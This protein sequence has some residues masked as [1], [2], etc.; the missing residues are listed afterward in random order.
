[1]PTIESLLHRRTDLS[2]FL[3][4]FTRDTPT[5]SAAARDNLLSIL[6]SQRLEARN[7][8]GMEIGR[9]HV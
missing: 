8:Y 3:V 7:T 9:A 5:P 1:M 2:T 4:H 6:G